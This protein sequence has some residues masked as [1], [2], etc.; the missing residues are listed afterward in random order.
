MRGRGGKESDVCNLCNEGLIGTAWHVLGEC[1][2]EGLVERRREAE[3]KLKEGLSAALG[4][5]REWE[6][7]QYKLMDSFQVKE[8]GTWVRAEGDL[9]VQGDK[10]GRSYN[11][12]FGKVEEQWLDEW[13]DGDGEGGIVR[14][15]QGVRQL[16]KCSELAVE[17]CRL[18]WQAAGEEWGK[19][20]RT[21]QQEERRAEREARR[22]KGRQ[23]REEAM[24][25]S[26]RVRGERDR[27]GWAKW[28][29]GENQKRVVEGRARREELRIR[30]KAVDRRTAREERFLGWKVWR[31]AKLRDWYSEQQQADQ[32]ARKATKGGGG[33]VKTQSQLPWRR[34][35]G[36]S[37]SIDKREGIGD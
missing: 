12:W 23:I 9:G 26:A 29:M 16:R 25:R 10:A 37:S 21:Q 33:L 20:A 1:R 7:W 5:Q 24:R 3:R 15:N 6:E 22:E 8:S 27:G 32:R 28:V 14:W 4:D 13:M 30:S 18:V 35:P 34:A 36:G 19:M 17:A 11:L 31:S 2:H